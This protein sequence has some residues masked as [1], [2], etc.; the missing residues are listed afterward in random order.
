MNALTITFAI[1]LIVAGCLFW[2]TPIPGGAPAMAIGFALLICSSER[3][4]NRILNWRINNVRFNRAFIF[5][6]DMA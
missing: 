1:I 2:L 3:A 6:E 5:I 4:A